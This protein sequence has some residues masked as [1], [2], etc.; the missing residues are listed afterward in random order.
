MC[1]ARPSALTRSARRI[2]LQTDIHCK[3]IPKNLDTFL[4]I[5]CLNFQIWEPECN[6]RQSVWYSDN[7]I[8]MQTKVPEFLGRETF[9]QLA[10]NFIKGFI[11]IFS[12]CVCKEAAD[13]LF[14]AV[15]T[16]YSHARWEVVSF[17]R[18]S[19][20]NMW[21]WNRSEITFWHPDLKIRTKMSKSVWI[22]KEI[23]YTCDII[24]AKSEYA[25]RRTLRGDKD[26]EN[27]LVHAVASFI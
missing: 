5:F 21:N 7:A 1:L 3:K 20:E 19:S 14:T 13:I 27:A 6:F 18:E 11:N 23:S 16:V 17:I 8:R 4:G 25:R 9:R 15:F 12:Y 24:R 22:F 26:R 10:T 2:I